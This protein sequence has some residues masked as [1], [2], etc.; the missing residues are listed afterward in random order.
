[1][2]LP[3]PSDL[4]FDALVPYGWG[5]R[6]EALYRVHPAVIQAAGASCRSLPVPDGGLA[7][8]DGRAAADASEVW[9]GQ[10]RRDSAVLGPGRVVRVERG[11]CFVVG[12]S[13]RERLSTAPGPVAVGDWVVL[14]AGRILDVLPRWAALERVDP[15]GGVVQVLAAN[16]DTV[17]V[18]IPADRPSASRAER[19]L[20]LAWE[21][22][23]RPVVALTKVDLA[24]PDSAADLRDRLRGVEVLEVSARTGVGLEAVATLLRGQTSVLLGPSGAG[25][26]SLV[27]ALAGEELQATG[28]VRAGDARGRHTT[29]SRHL[30]ALGGGA[31]VIDTPGLRSLALASA[32]HI[33]SAFPDV[34]ALAVTCRFRDC[35]H[36]REPGCA[37]R[38][39]VLSGELPQAR[40]D[41]YRKLAREAAIEARRTDPFARLEER[42]RAK[43]R[44]RAARRNRD[45]R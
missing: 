3:F 25:K 18:T 38:A 36:D 15:A 1:M 30:L 40:L 43:Q 37:L 29:T 7:G 24:A 33:D 45:E 39:A 31:V 9:P 11:G 12:G 6:A 19:E 27:N 10:A 32:N 23:A 20:T 2:S 14:E 42:R 8:V 4:S 44:S 13:G 21:S 26:S 35:R 16:V 22:G 41:S 28:A 34:E 5:P 17:V